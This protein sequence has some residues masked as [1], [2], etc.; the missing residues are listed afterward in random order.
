MQTVQETTTESSSEMADAIAKILIDTKDYKFVATLA[1]AAY[2]KQGEL[3]H[4]YNL[5][6]AEGN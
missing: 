3:E 6:T 5:I 2:S 4:A 1:R